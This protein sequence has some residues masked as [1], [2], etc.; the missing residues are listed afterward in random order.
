VRACVSNRDTDPPIQKLLHAVD[1]LHIS[2]YEALQRKKRANSWN[3]CH[4]RVEC[5]DS[6]SV[7]KKLL[8]FRAC[9]FQ[10]VSLASGRAVFSSCGADPSK[11]KKR[12]SSPTQALRAASCENHRHRPPGAPLAACS[13]QL[14][15]ATSYELR[16]RGALCFV[17]VFVS[18]FLFLVP[19]IMSCPTHHT[20]PYA[21]AYACS[22]CLCTCPARGAPA[23][24]PTPVCGVLL[25]PGIWH[26]AFFFLVARCVMRGLWAI[27]ACRVVAGH[28]SAV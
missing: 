8:G 22:L 23:P 15:R 16:G 11:A 25:A 10:H 20:T 4:S 18:C 13:L 19:E 28:A 1:I 5:L 27:C 12:L 14:L 6:K 2:Y 7:I 9:N 3:D 24:A 21:C 26:L 17:F